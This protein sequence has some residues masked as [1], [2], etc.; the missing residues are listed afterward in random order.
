MRS[1]SMVFA[2]T[3]QTQSNGPILT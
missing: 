1:N 2:S 3:T